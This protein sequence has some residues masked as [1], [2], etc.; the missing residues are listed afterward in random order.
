MSPN[1]NTTRRIIM[2][3][4]RMRN[5]IT[6]TELQEEIA[7]ANGYPWVEPGKMVK[8]YLSD[9]EYLG[10]LRREPDS[11]EEKYVIALGAAR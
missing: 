10:V 1:E 5:P 2:E 4:I 7:S 9:L 11:Q 8:D 3:H 6:L